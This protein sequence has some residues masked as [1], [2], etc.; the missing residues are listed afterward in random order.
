[1]SPE[2]RARLRAA[3]IKR[4]AEAEAALEEASKL[5]LS[6]GGHV[7]ATD[8]TRALGADSANRPHTLVAGGLRRATPQPE[9]PTP[10]IE[11]DS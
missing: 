6:P 7:L 8:Y 5:R 11:R 10:A 1:M 3:L 2:E 4:I 9:Y